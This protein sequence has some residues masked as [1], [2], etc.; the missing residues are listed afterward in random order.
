L[1]LPKKLVREALKDMLIESLVTR[2]P[3][4]PPANRQRAEKHLATTF[5]VNPVVAR[6]RLSE[7]FPDSKGQVEF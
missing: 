5:D 2:N 7:M 6:I 3:S 1:L 4:L